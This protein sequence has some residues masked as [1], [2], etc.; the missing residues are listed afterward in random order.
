MY[1]DTCKSEYSNTVP[2]SLYAAFT[3]LL[4]ILGSYFFTYNKL[5][6]LNNE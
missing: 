3:M 1:F 2:A 6:Y 4:M 5:Y